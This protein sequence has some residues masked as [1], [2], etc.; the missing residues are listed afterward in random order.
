MLGEQAGCGA[1]T[2]SPQGGRNPSR[3]TAW[4]WGPETL[5]DRMSDIPPFGLPASV[6]QGL[7]LLE[8]FFP[9]VRL[10]GSCGLGAE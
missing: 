4:Q 6:R 3:T 10:G 2:G 1:D 7:G 5:S 8:D 9:T